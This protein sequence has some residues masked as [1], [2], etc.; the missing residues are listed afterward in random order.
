MLILHFWEPF[1]QHN[2]GLEGDTFF[3]VAPRTSMDGNQTWL[4][5]E[6]RY[7]WR[8]QLWSPEGFFVP[9]VGG[10]PAISVLLLTSVCLFWDLICI[11]SG[12]LRVDHIQEKWMHPYSIA[13]TPKTSQDCFLN[14]STLLCILKYDKRTRSES[15]WKFINLG[16]L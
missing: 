6:S 1:S 2:H 16:K 13:A 9:R 15:S 7:K 14:W 10:I 5:G 3:K 8:F 12:Y 4:A 11:C